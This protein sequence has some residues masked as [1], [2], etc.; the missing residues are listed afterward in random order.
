MEEK[1]TMDDF[2]EEL[3]ASYKAAEESGAQNSEELDPVWATL[4]QYMD[5]KEVLNVKIGG[6]VNRLCRWC[7]RIHSCIPSVSG[8]CRR[9][10]RVAQQKDPCPRDHC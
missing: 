6:V 7:S 1:L 2:K 4:Q 9:S 3:E 8:S 10:E 5:D